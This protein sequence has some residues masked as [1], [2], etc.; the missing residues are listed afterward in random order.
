METHF[1]KLLKA[2]CLPP[3]LIRKPGLEEA[4]RTGS[5][6]LHTLIEGFNI[7][8]DQILKFRITTFPT[9]H[10]MKPAAC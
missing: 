6:G 3:D 1:P 4:E 10:E 5:P 7:S 8:P 2:D 9:V